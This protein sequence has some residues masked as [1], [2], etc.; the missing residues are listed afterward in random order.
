MKISGVSDTAGVVS[1]AS[2]TFLIRRFEKIFV[3]ASTISLK[4]LIHF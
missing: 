4:L 2:Q 1:A 3:A